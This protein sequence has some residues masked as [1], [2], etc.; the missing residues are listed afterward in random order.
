MLNI[1]I[2][3]INGRLDGF[4]DHRNNMFVLNDDYDL[5]REIC[6]KLFEIYRVEDFKWRN[7]LVRTLASSLFKI[8]NRYLPESSYNSRTREILDKFEP[9]A[10]YYCDEM[11]FEDD[12]EP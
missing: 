1:Y 9:F 3:I 10:L 5:R 11:Y 12:D 2:G 4:I 8:Q 6:E 7:Q